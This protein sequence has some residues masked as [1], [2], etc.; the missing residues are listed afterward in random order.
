[1]TR[2][3]ARE[4]KFCCNSDLVLVLLCAIR[5]VFLLENISLGLPYIYFDYD[6]FDNIKSIGIKAIFIQKGFAQISTP[7]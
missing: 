4:V 2:V 7:N 1:M 6:S 3:T 5:K